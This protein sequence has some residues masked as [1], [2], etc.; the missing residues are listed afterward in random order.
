VP[1]QNQKLL[2]IR[3]PTSYA[4][5]SKA[6]VLVVCL[7]IREEFKYIPATLLLGNFKL[8]LKPNNNPY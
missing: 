8:L 7:P 4:Q 6:N 2:L 5:K 1:K 3:K